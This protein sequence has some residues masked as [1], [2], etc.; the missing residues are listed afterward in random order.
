M[1][2]IHSTSR[3]RQAGLTLISW[4]VVIAFLGFQAVLAMN[5]IPVYIS[6]NSVKSVMASME[7]DPDMRKATSKKIKA[8]LLK[9]LKINSVYDITNDNI[10]VTKGKSGTNIALVYEPRGTLVGNLEFIIRFEHQA[11]IR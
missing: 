10:T 8:T 1:N 2:A 7:T 3:N 6:D 4:I 9:K 11:V 5:V